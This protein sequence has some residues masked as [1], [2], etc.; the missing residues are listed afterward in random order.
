[1]STK[2]LSQAYDFFSDFGRSLYRP[3]RGLAIIWAVFFAIYW[4]LGAIALDLPIGKMSLLNREAFVDAALL[5]SDK[6]FPFGASVDE[7]TLFSAKLLGASGGASA[8]FV[9]ILGAIQLILSGIMVFLAGLA[10]RTKLL[11]G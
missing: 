10:I 6:T 8:V 7:D 11:I 5:S 4:L 9:G 1:M 3:I 2:A